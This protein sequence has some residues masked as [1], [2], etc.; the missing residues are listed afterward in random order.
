MD[1]STCGASGMTK[2]EQLRDQI[3]RD[4]A[5]LRTIIEEP[6]SIQYGE[7]VDFE[8]RPDNDDDRILVGREM[9]GFTTVN[10]TSEGLIIDVLAQDELDVIH[11]AAFP[12][13]ELEVPEE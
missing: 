2:I 5:Y 3:E 4:I 7:F 12:Y 10:Y 13:D 6:V 9:W 1:D 11:T 8:V